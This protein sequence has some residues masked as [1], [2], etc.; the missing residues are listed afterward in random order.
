MPSPFGRLSVIVNAAAGRRTARAAV[1]NLERELSARGLDH[2]I[3][4]TEGPGDATRLARRALEQG[5]RFVVAVGGDGTVHE[6]VN[7]MVDDGAAVVPGAVLGVVP[8]GSGCDFVRTFGLPTAPAAAARLDGAA[9]RPLDVARIR[10][11]GG[12]GDAVVRHFVNVAEAG[13]GAAT[14]RRAVGLPRFLG[15]SRY[16]FAFWAALPSFRPCAVRTEVDG[17][18]AHEGR[19]VNVVV[20]N[21]RYFGGGMHI[22]PSSDPADGTLELLAFTGRKTDSFTMLPR[23]YRGTHVPHRSIVE[24]AGRSFRIEPEEAYP[25]EADGEVLGMTPLTVDVIPGAVSLKV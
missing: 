23:V 11:I 2:D 16:F 1:G 17:A 4:F 21:A 9:V 12:T 22:S 7:G 19:A 15:P 3:R 10:C 8:A 24:L 6:V 25:V 5:G 13:L 20:A 14:T 18:V